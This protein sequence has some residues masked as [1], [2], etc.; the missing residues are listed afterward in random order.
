MSGSGPGV[1]IT[2]GLARGA[3]RLRAWTLNEELNEELNE[4]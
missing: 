4:A 3:D 1:P 2:C